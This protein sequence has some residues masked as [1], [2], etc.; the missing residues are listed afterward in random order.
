MLDFSHQL[1]DLPL[2][3]HRGISFRLL[4]RSRLHLFEERLINEVTQLEFVGLDAATQSTIHEYLLHRFLV[5]RCGRGRR[6]RI[7]DVKLG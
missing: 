3:L 5:V 6:I 4:V 2:L 1:A 7:R